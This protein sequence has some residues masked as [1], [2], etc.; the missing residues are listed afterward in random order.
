MFA[1]NRT[2]KVIGRITF[3]IVS[4]KTIK[5]VNIPGDPIGTKWIIILL[6]WLI[7][8]YNIKEIQIGKANAIENIIW[9]EGV[10]T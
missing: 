5:I 3:L 1:D 6:K 10:N 7:H 2:D 8:P 4:I 9:L